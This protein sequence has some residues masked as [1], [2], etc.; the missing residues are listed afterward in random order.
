M[1]ASCQGRPRQRRRASRMTAGSTTTLGPWH[2]VR[3]WTARPGRALRAR[4]RCGSG[5]GCPRGAMRVTSSNQPLSAL[6]HRQRAVAGVGQ[7]QVDGCA[8]PAPTAGIDASVGRRVR[9]RTACDG[10]AGSCGM[11]RPRRWI[12]SDAAS[13]PATDV[14]RRRQHARA[15]ARSSPARYPV[16][17]RPAVRAV[18]QELRQRETEWPR[19]AH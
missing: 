11:P 12:S 4:R 18:G 16:I 7:H 2:I 6:V 19:D 3:D 15:I 8:A 1:T 13:G 14:L 9:R 17:E 5:S 10:S